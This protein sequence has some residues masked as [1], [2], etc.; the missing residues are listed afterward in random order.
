LFRSNGPAKVSP[1]YQSSYLPA[2]PFMLSPQQRYQQDLQKPGFSHD[3]QQARVMDFLQKVYENL[4]RRR[5]RS[6]S[7][8]FQGKLKTTL[9]GQAEAPVRGLY[10][11]GGVGRG[12]TYLM[13]TFFESL[14]FDDKLRAHFHRFM[15]RVHQELTQ[16]AG[17]ADPLQ[18]VAERI[19][20]ETSIIC[21]DE[22]FVSDI[23]DA[24]LLGNLF[25]ALFQNGVSLVATSNIP[26]R[27]LYKDGLQRER[28]LPAIHLIEQH[29]EVIHLDS[30]T[31][32]RLRVLERA[33]LYHQPLDEMAE[34]SLA[35][36]FTQLAPEH[37]H[38]E[39]GI[40][41]DIEGRPIRAHKEAEDVVWFDFPAICD[42]PRSQ[43]DYIEI[44]K[45]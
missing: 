20:K 21:F 8:R 12:K 6:W 35:Q 42:G 18:L 14:P 30:P 9:S 2:S 15:R 40:N 25:Q 23:T 27:D 19:S 22:F 28:F 10:V 37:A 5:Q 1:F 43:N 31:D 13:D 4:M 24:M 32:Y 45:E 16:L 34:Q 33:E 17:R 11:W 41:L 36:S 44:A 38:I 3:P 29:T 7:E 26:P 39:E